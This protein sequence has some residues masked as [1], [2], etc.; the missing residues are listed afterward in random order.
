QTN[1]ITYHGPMVV[2][3]GKKTCHKKT[4]ETFKQMFDPTEI[5]YD[6]LIS[7]LHIINEGEATGQ[8]V[9]GNLSLIVS[10][11]KTP[12]EIELD[13]NIL[14]IEDVEEPPYK[15]YLMLN[16]LTSAGKLNN[17]KGI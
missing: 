2:S 5:V 12:Y 4:K 6:E 3:V 8:I 14:R 9:G 13:Y 10:S 1:L 17:V 11:L 16:Q 15:F 7:K